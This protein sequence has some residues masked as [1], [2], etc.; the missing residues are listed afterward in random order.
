M[1]H[2]FEIV[3]LGLELFSRC[4]YFSGRTEKVIYT[5]KMTAQIF[6]DSQYYYFFSS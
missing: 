3:F 1:S 4:T 6:L 5:H 2:G